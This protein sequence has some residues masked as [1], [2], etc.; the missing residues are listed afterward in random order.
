MADRGSLQVLVLIVTYIMASLAEL[1]FQVNIDPN[2]S[3]VVAGYYVDESFNI[4]QNTA[5][6]NWGYNRVS[7]NLTGIDEWVVNS[8]ER[9]SVPDCTAL[10]CDGLVTE[11][12][13]DEV[14]ELYEYWGTLYYA[15]RTLWFNIALQDDLNQMIGSTNHKGDLGQFKK[16][17]V[18]TFV[19][20]YLVL[21]AFLL[22]EAITGYIVQ[23]MTDKYND[24]EEGEGK[25]F[26]AVARVEVVKWFALIK[27][28]RTLAACPPGLRDA[29][30][31]IDI[32][33]VEHVKQM[34]AQIKDHCECATTAGLSLPSAACL[35]ADCAV[36]S[37]GHSLIKR[38]LVAMHRQPLVRTDGVRN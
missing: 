18:V 6:T 36:F 12:T 24:G 21:V 5:G 8:T 2:N 26:A 22:I 33:S 35:G 15:M 3:D 14:A 16:L 25:E 38:P 9:G 32:E 17:V 27:H 30:M 29:Y 34:L 11:V 13:A 23:M 7:N 1:L 37:A 31:S 28:P 4:V 10:G 20:C 19:M